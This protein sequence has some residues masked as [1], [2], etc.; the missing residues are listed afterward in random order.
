ME[1]KVEDVSESV[2]QQMSEVQQ[3][4]INTTNPPAEYTLSSGKKVKFRKPPGL[5][6]MQIA[7]ILGDQSL[8]PALN[9][10]YRMAFSLVEVDGITV[11]TPKSKPEITATL[12]RLGDEE[13][14]AEALAFFT[15]FMGM[16]MEDLEAA[17]K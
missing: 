11:R 8:N 14:F 13:S 3:Q 16:S 1:I 7:E 2:G 4:V 9:I 10:Y 12:Q 5:V 6:S 17:K 15:E